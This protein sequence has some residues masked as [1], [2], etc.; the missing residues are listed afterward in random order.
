MRKMRG[1]GQRSKVQHLFCGVATAALLCVSVARSAVADEAARAGEVDEIPEIVVTAQ[2]RIQTLQE[3]PIS[4]TVLSGVTILESHLRDFS[5]LSLQTPSF[6][7]GTDYGYIRNSSMRGISNNQYGFA[8]DPSIAMYV[9]DIYQ[10][11]GASGMQV[12]ALYDIDRVEIIKG[13]QATLFGRSS[14]AGAISTILLQPKDTFSASGDF[15]AGQRDRLIARGTL[16]IPVTSNLAI[17]VAVDSEHQG[18]FITNLNGGSKLDPLDVKAER[19]IARYTGIDK[20]EATLKASYESRRQD[21]STHLAVGVPDVENFTADE[22]LMGD[23]N[24][25]DFYSFEEDAKLKYD[26]LNNL[27]VTSET[28]WRRVKN[29]YIEKYDGVPEIIGGPYY[30]DSLDSLFQQDLRISISGPHNL[31]ITA[32]ASYFHETLHGLINNWTDH[33][34]AFTGVPGAGLLPNNYSQAIFEE[35]HF[36]GIFRGRSAFVDGTMSI[37]GVPGWTITAGA[38]YNYDEK[39]FTADLPN[40]ATLPEN[41][42]KAFACACGLWGFYTDPPLSLTHHWS[43]TSFR[44]A[45]N[46]DLNENNTVYLQYSQGWKAGGIDATGIKVPPGSGFLKYF[47]E[48]ASAFGATLNPYNPERS[49]SYE[50]GLKGRAFARRFAYNLAA[51]EYLYRD[52]QVAVLETGASVIE[53]IGH[54]TGRGVEAELRL[55]PNAHWDVYANGAFNYTRIEDFGS[56]SSQV[57]LPLNQAPRYNAA[58]GS[59]YKWT[60]NSGQYSVGASTSMRGSYRDDNDLDTHEVRSYI[61]YN[62]RAAYETVDGHYTAAIFADNLSNRFTYSRFSAAQPFVY[63]VSSYQVIGQPRTVG[64]DLYV[65]Y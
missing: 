8:D 48:N 23:Q 61:L 60:A 49:D 29:N 36:D 39:T 4:V 34:F 10:G 3:V 58:A 46:Y 44:A 7:S 42:G 38:R 30:Q 19:V 15:G 51:Y 21:G 33:T 1:L 5:D 11:R 2:H 13:P 35:G 40:P 50:I 6:T 27:S 56:M 28:S 25:A 17:R 52:L 24:F 55:A 54:A 47:G 22:T 65:R 57:G 32:G 43:N 31:S 64:I 12:N 16:N 20:L 18:G 14:I 45:T 63:P 62:V 26:F 41:I 53:N 59:T 9:D 37:P